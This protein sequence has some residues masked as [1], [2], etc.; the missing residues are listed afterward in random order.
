[1]QV[2]VYLV[3]I[4]SKYVNALQCFKN[5]FVVVRVFVNR[6]PAIGIL[7]HYIVIDFGKSKAK[8]VNP[9][10][11]SRKVALMSKMNAPI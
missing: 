8:G 11:K 9:N 5:I 6:S 1:M 10:R 7:H 2:H 3:L 4:T